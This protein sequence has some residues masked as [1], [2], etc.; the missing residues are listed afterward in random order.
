MNKIICNRLELIHVSDVKGSGNG[1]VEL[2]NNKSF[3]SVV[4]E[5]K[6]KYDSQTQK[7]ASGVLKNET[8]SA[9]IRY[10][11][12][13]RILQSDLQNYILRLYTDKESF[14]V[15]S[16]DYPAK[17]TYTSDKIYVNLTFKT[18]SPA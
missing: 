18:S 15:G 1:N 3:T 16:V 14:I 13:L 17:L 10:N 8:V 2:K 5:E 4:L 11:D 6:A 7:N 12:D 9:K